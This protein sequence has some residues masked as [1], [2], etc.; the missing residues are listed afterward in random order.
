VLKDQAPEWENDSRWEHG[1]DGC[2]REYT[3][4]TRKLWPILNDKWLRSLPG[5]DTCVQHLKSDPVIGSHLDRLV[6]TN[7][8]AR[9]LDADTLLLSAINAMPNDEGAFVFTDEQFKHAWRELVEFFG[10]KQIAFKMVA[11]LPYL[12]VPNLPLRLN[13]DLVLDR[14]TEDEVTR[15]CQ[16]GVIRP[17]SL[18]FPLIDAAVA[19]GIRRTIFL[20]KVIRTDDEPPEQLDTVNEGRFGSRPLL[21]DDLVV[22]DVL[23][24]LRLFKHT[25]V[26][27][28]SC[29]PPLLIIPMA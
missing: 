28:G 27:T 1:D 2:F 13:N 10:A 24:A 8:I 23:S 5:Y 4:R 14:L 26:R 19:V 3:K 7:T 9:R 25:Q 18:R 17:Q 16:I 29:T 6:G 15:C 21:R 20:P 22:D 12:M 11:P